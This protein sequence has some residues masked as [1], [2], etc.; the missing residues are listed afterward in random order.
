MQVAVR[1]VDGPLQEL[2]QSAVLLQP[3][4]DCSVQEV[5]ESA[6]RVFSTGF[7]SSCAT[8]ANDTREGTEIFIEVTRQDK[9][10]K[11]SHTCQPA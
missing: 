2:A 7:F 5:K 6:A 3:G 11:K 1:G 9:T 8:R 10:R 4:R